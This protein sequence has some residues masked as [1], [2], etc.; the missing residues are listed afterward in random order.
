MRRLSAEIF[1]VSFKI[2]IKLFNCEQIKLIWSKLWHVDIFLIDK[3]LLLTSW[4]KYRSALVVIDWKVESVYKIKC[5]K[6]F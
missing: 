6:K 5:R 2:I 1:P 4:K 3:N